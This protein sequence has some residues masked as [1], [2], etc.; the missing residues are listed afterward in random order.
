MLQENFPDLNQLYGQ[1]SLSGY[2]GGQQID[3]A[4][5]SQ[6]IN[7]QSALQDMYQKEQMLPVDIGMK[8]AQ[9]KNYGASTEHMGENTRAQKFKND[10]DEMFKS[11]QY[12][13]E[14]AKFRST[15]SKADLD[16]ANNQIKKLM[17]HDDAKTRDVAQ[18]LRMMMDDVFPDYVKNTQRHGQRLEEI[19]ATGVNQANTASIRAEATKGRVGGVNALEKALVS[20][21]PL[22]VAA[23]YDQM[24]QRS[25]DPEEQQHYLLKSQ[26][27]RRIAQQQDISRNPGSAPG[28]P[29]MGEMGIPVNPATPP[30]EKPI[31]KGQSTT[32][33]YEKGK[34][35]KG[36]TGTY[37]Y[38]G[39]DP[40]NKASWKKIGD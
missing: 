6:Q 35:Y 38:I 15:M 22:Q 29:N 20:G 27:Y 40:A 2:M 24:A 30:A 34:Q 16:D 28:K 3:Q 7:Q 4:R 11:E 5:K 31:V 8:Q 9:T 19:N 39:G 21:N 25:E 26:E 33:Q 1:G 23:A 18:Q 17:L 12:Q 32:G 36:D 13:A 14:K 10:M 37:E